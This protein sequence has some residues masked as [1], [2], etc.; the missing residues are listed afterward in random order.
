VDS[1]CKGKDQICRRYQRVVRESGP[2]RR[3]IRDDVIVGVPEK[4]IDDFPLEQRRGLED[5]A[6]DNLP[7][8]LFEILAGG[9]DVELVAGIIDD[10]GRV[11][12]VEEDV[13]NGFLRIVT[14]VVIA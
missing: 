4:W 14:F 6:D 10:R 5:V 11:S 2:V 12:I 3:P 1:R 7:L 13:T 8:H 9:E